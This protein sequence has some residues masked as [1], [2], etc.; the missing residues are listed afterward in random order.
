LLASKVFILPEVT[1]FEIGS[2]QKM[3]VIWQVIVA[4]CLVLSNPKD[5]L[6]LLIV[7]YSKDTYAK[8]MAH[9]AKKPDKTKRA[10]CPFPTLFV[11]GPSVSIT[12]MNIHGMLT[13]T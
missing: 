13:E 4:F 6:S 12:R 10:N 7:Q 2:E 5:S 9:N 8:K 1:P 11:M 3:S